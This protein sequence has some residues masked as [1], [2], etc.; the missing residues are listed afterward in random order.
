[1]SLNGHQNPAGLQGFLSD[2]LPPDGSASKARPRTRH[3]NSSLAS[4]KVGGRTYPLVAVPS[5]AVCK[6]PERAAI[7]NA[8]VRGWS[9]TSIARQVGEEGVTPRNIKAHFDNGHMPISD[10]V[11][12]RLHEDAEERGRVVEEGVEVVLDGLALARRVRAAVIERLDN[13][14]LPVTVRDGLAAEA[15]LVRADAGENFDNAALLRG[16]MTWVESIKRHC[17]PEQVAAIGADIHA[18]PALATVQALATGQRHP[19]EH[20]RV[21]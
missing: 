17:T 9:Q 12:A 8:F 14:E 3:S 13:G 15:L 7:E 2:D 19:E 5:C 10:E 20:V 21:R 6:S 16:F 11:A 1:M 18:E 4:T